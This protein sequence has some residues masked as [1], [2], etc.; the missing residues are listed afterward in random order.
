MANDLAPL[1]KSE[2]SRLQEHESVIERGQKTFIEVGNAL[3]AIKEGKLYKARYKTF[4]EYTDVKWGWGASRARQLIAA[5]KVADEVKSVTNVTLSNEG[6]ARE[7]VKIEPEHRAFIVT[8]ASKQ[9]EKDGKPL[10]AATIAEVV[11]RHNPTPH[12][13]SHNGDGAPFDEP[14][15]VD[16]G[17]VV[18]FLTACNTGK[19]KA[20]KEQRAKFK[21]YDEDSQRAFVVA[22][23]NGWQSLSNALSTGEVAEPPIEHKIKE[24]AAAID[25]DCRAM[26]KA[27]ADFVTLFKE[28]MAKPHHNGPWAKDLKRRQ[29]ALDKFDSA[30]QVA[31]FEDVLETIRSWKT[32]KPCPMCKGDGCDKCHTTGMLTTQAYQQLV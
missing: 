5:A 18:E 25:A 27:L 13:P 15:K 7:V 22:I 4:E 24:H 19:I 11:E 14:D 9:A 29:A 3:F 21:E 16:D 6:I 28:T 30:I 32:S 23:V 17:L 2:L 10:T 20:T 31:K 12:E 8:E 1:T 26:R